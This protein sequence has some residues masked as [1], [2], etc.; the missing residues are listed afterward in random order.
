MHC[1]L[2]QSSHQE[3]FDV[4]VIIHLGGLKDLGTPDVLAFPKVSVCLDCGF[5][6]FLIS[7]TELLVLRR[8]DP[9]VDA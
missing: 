3:Q 5:S 9:A 8:G 4:E 2:C 6:T 1:T 7:E